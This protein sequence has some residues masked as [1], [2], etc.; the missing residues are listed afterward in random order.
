MAVGTGVAVDVA[1]GVDVLVDVG[2]GVSAA[3]TDGPAAAKSR[4]ADKPEQLR[5][6]PGA[7]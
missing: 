3:M 5:R 2:V 1:V 7:A 4:Q 6:R